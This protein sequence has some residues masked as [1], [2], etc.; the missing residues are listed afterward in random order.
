MGQSEFV[1]LPTPVEAKCSFDVPGAPERPVVKVA[2]PQAALVSWKPPEKDGGSPVTSFT[3]EMRKGESDW[4]E[5]SATIEVPTQE[6]TVENL[7]VTADFEFRVAASNIA[8][9]GPFS[10]PSEPFTLGK[11]SYS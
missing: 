10:E 9:R 2:G 1:E 8:G 5:V 7:D 4:T 3:L 11:L 6:Y